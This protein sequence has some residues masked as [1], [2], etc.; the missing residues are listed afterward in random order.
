MA[1]NAVVIGAGLAGTACAARLAERGWSVDLVERHGTV[2]QEASGNAAGLLMPAFSAD[3]NPPTRLT[4]PACLYA[5]RAIESLAQRGPDSGW[6]R[7]GVLQLARDQAHFERLRRIVETFALADEMAQLVD[8][9]Q[10]AAIAGVDVAGAGWWLPMAGWAHPGSVCRAHLSAAGAAVRALFNSEA[11]H[12]RSTGDEWEVLDRI[13]KP[14]ARGRAIVVANALDAHALT[15]IESLPLVSTR[16]Q[17][18]LLPAQSGGFLRAPVCREGYITPA[19]GGVH[20]VGAS[21]DLHSHDPLPTLA[22]HAGNL[23]RLDRLLPRFARGVDVRTLEGRVGF[24]AVS[25]DRMP[26]A[27]ALLPSGA[28]AGRDGLFACLALA[29]RGL[30]W[31]PLLGE[32]VACLATGEPLPVEREMLGWL[33]PQR[34]G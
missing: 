25:P 8:R 15:G 33:D 5:L 16:G 32:V 31:A 23:E 1:R 11:G 21:Y 18:S 30:T 24:R 29:S 2:A 14:L 17:V 20:C 34:F 3:W 9:K 10:G 28:E 12:I 19:M 27:G 6:Q 4:A 7:S 13:G 26:L 22:D